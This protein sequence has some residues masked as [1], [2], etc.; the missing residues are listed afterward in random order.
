VLEAREAAALG[1]TVAQARAALDELINGV[2]ARWKSL[3]LIS[4]T[5]TLLAAWR[6]Q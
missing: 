1:L 6:L 3:A 2:M 5:R 4:G